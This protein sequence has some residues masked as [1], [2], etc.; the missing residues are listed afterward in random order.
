MQPESLPGFVEKSVLP[1]ND[2]V[3]PGILKVVI[4]QHHLIIWT[5]Q[6]DMV[7]FSQPLVL[8][9]ACK[10]YCINPFL[11]SLLWPRFLNLIFPVMISFYSSHSSSKAQTCWQ[12]RKWNSSGQEAPIQN[13]YLLCSVETLYIWNSEIFDF[14]QSEE[15]PHE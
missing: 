10:G 11:S 2:L 7:K 13:W 15:K 3:L 6:W 9:Y 1:L 4:K 8:P 14:T 12:T 5:R